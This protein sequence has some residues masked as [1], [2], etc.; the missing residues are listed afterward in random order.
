M[1]NEKSFQQ[2]SN[3]KKTG[4]KPVDPNEPIS[5]KNLNEAIYDYTKNPHDF[6]KI[7]ADM[8]ITPDMLE[9]N[10]RLT[11]NITMRRSSFFPHEASN[12]GR[13][14]RIH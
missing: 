6:E 10:G 11:A 8:G 2:A 13:V 3:L 1:F 7:M 9:R 5:E 14:G 12:K 4:E